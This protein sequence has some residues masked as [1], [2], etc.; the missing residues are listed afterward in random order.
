MTDYLAPFHMPEFSDDAFLEKKRGY[1]RDHG[2]SITLPKFRDVIHLGMHKPMTTPEKIL[3]MSGRRHEIGKSRQIELYYQKERNRERYHKMLASPIPNVISSITSVLTAMDDTQDAIISLAA[4]GR[5]ACVFLPRVITSVLAWPIGLLWFLATIMSLI[6]AP[7][8]CALNPMGC[9]RYIRGKLLGR[10]NTLKAKSMKLGKRTKQLAK[11]EASRLAA[12]VKG[13]ATSGTF[14]PSFAEGIQMLQVTDNIWG[15]GI[16]L[17]P[18][19]GAAYDLAS[20]GVRWAMG[21]DVTFKNAPSDVEVYRKA[22]DKHNNY[23]RWKRPKTKMTRSEFLTWKARKVAS[24]TWGIKSLQ[25]DAIHQARRLHEHNY[26]VKRHTDWTEETLL[27]ANAEIAAQGNQI[28]LNHWDPVLNIEGAEHIEIEAY[29][30]PSPLVEEMLIEEGVDPFT[31]IGWPSLGK[32]WA[33]YEELQTSIAPIAAGNIKY[34]SEN[35]TNEHYKDIAEKSATAC[36]LMAIS[37]MI[38][39][40]FIDIQHHVGIDIAEALLDKGYSFPRTIKEDQV[41]D[42]AQWTQT[43]ED[44]GTRPNLWDALAYAKN[45]LGFE[46]QT[47]Y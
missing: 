19:F 16:S 10:S 28:T 22:A 46:F 3:W 42:F 6:M 8:M 12:G 32:R 39:P 41:F 13:Y 45:S 31:R 23:A 27:Y 33:S 38:G 25:H 1:T 5:I 30:E 14:M 43:H 21:Q 40:G 24:G 26:G 15:V 44:S 35:C 11:Y 4:I 18:I 2:Y 7:S 36:G 9:K 37:G 17:G 47:K 29:N 34:F 20:G